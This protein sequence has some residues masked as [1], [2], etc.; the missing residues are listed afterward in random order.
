MRYFSRLL[1]DPFVV[2][3][4]FQFWSYYLRKGADR[5]AAASNARMMKKRRR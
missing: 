1:P 2:R 5:H 4:P 3:K